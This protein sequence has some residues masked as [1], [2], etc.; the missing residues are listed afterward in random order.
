MRHRIA[1]RPAESDKGVRCRKESGSAPVGQFLRPE[2]LAA[3]DD[4]VEVKVV[5][6][7]DELMGEGNC[8]HGKLLF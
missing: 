8:M 2:A 5:L 6:D 7:G 3:F 4:L 1:H